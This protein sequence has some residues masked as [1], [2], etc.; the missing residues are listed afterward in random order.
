MT[1]RM[2]NWDFLRDMMCSNVH[3]AEEDI[4]ES[5]KELKV[6]LPK[7]DMDGLTPINRMIDDCKCVNTRDGLEACIN[8]WREDLSPAFRQ[9]R[10]RNDLFENFLETL[11]NRVGKTRKFL[12][13]EHG[14]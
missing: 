8:I 7:R 13:I 1:Y 10:V 5:L 12:A 2:K 14:L 3:I 4:E 6:T 9:P 11:D